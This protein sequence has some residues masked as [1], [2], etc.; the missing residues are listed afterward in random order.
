MQ[1]LNSRV[2][3]GEQ[4]CFNSTLLALDEDEC[5][6][7]GTGRLTTWEGYTV[8]DKYEVRWAPKRGLTLWIK[9]KYLRP[10]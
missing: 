3:G 6:A 2:G 7:S 8:P 4:E 10:A 5:S 9:E 1:V